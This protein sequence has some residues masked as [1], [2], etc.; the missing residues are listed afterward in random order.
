MEVILLQDVE[1][2]GKEGDIVKVKDGFARNFLIPQKIAAP[3]SSQAVRMIEARKRKRVFDEEKT[4]RDAEELAKKVSLL[5][6][7]I[8]VE[9]GVDDKIFGTVTPEMVRNAIRQEGIEI[10]K[11]QIIISEPIKKLGVYQ[12]EIKLH[13]EITTSIRIWV[14]KK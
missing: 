14:V 2:L 1:S 8:A 11:K 12:I 6:C 13:P 10:D 5:S 9:S 4:K 3:S 7:T